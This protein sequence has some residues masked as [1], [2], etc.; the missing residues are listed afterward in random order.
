[1]ND[2]SS[3]HLINRGHHTDQAS[4]YINYL[5]SLRSR[6]SSFC[7]CFEFVMA[8][9]APTPVASTPATLKKSNSSSA[10]KSIASFFSKT[11]T[12]AKPVSLPERSSPRKATSARPNFSASVRRSNL[13]PVPSS[14]AIEPDTTYDEKVSHLF[15]TSRLL[16]ETF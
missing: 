6:S 11:P 5:R 10:Q 16:S 12:T 2:A 3:R 7:K 15:L 14:D 9:K 8:K 4:K 1:M 13:T